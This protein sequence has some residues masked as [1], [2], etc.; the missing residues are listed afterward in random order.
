MI[1]NKNPSFL[2]LMAITILCL[3]SFTATAGNAGEI[4]C[5]NKSSRCWN[6][7]FGN[8]D[9]PNRVL[10]L[11]D[12]RTR[13]LAGGEIEVDAVQ[14]FEAKAAPFDYVAYTMQ[15]QCKKRKVNLVKLYNSDWNGK[16]TGGAVPE[17]WE[18]VPQDSW[19]LNVSDVACNS[20]RTKA[21]R[22]YF[23]DSPRPVDAAWLARRIFWEMSFVPK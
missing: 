17:S 5:A 23:M 4:V 8:G 20:E 3:S 16:V 12:T 1:D 7:I 11:A 9:A 22:Q 15:F 19:I 6:L 10:Y 21:F 13:T 2:A 14:L 18:P